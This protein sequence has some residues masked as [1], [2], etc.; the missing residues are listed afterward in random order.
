VL[1]YL[2]LAALAS[3]VL[4][5]LAPAVRAAKPQLAEV[6]KKAG[7][8]AGL[9]GGSLLRKGVVIA[10]VALSFVL[11]VGG[12]LMVRSFIA[13]ANTDPGYD[14]RNV[15]TFG[16]G[17]F[18]G[19]PE[20]RAAQIRQLREEFEALPGVSRVTAVFPLP[21]DGSIINSRWGKEEAVTDP[22]KFQQAN[23]HI[24]IPGYFETM[25]TRLLAGRTFT[26]ADNRNDFMGVVVDD[27]LAQAA[28]PN[29]RWWSTSGTRL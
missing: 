20:L 23:V 13:L 21:L 9:G 5:G 14:P 28:F 16:A 17:V 25:G 8:N 27:L 18:G 6:L 15:L 22:S 4:F 2:M 10:E 1:G 11:L 24:V 12:G 29:E 3:A 7:R 26:E 19:T